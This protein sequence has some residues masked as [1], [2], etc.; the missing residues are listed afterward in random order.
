M[1]QAGKEARAPCAPDVTEHDLN[2]EVEPSAGL[3]R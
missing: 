1:T 2:W 3:A